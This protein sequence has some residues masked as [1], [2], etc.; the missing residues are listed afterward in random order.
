MNA[1]IF[2]VIGMTANSVRAPI[3]ASA[4]AGNVNVLPNGTY[5]DILLVNARRHIK[6]ALPRTANISTNY[7]RDTGNVF[8]ASANALRDSIRDDTVRTAR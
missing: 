4:I 1:I 3:M 8:A 7:V 5:R 2:H 6:H